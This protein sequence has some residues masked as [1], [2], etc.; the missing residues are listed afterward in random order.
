MLFCKKKVNKTFI[1]FI[2]FSNMLKFDHHLQTQ[3]Q[4][5]SHAKNFTS[6]FHFF[7]N[8]GFY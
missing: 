8:F 2:N 4:N 5:K 1:H 6:S 7:Y 3:L